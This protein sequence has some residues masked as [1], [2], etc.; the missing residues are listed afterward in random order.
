LRLTASRGIII[1]SKNNP[2]ALTRRYD[3]TSEVNRMS[4]PSLRP[5]VPGR[6]RGFTL[7]ELLVVIGI[8]ALLIS[9]LLPALSKAR[10]SAITVK[11]A[12]ALRQIGMGYQLY[13]NDQRG[14][15][16][17]AKLSPDTGSYELNGFQH[18]A[19]APAYWYNFVAYYVNQAAVGG[20]IQT[21]VDADAA[22]KGVL[23]GCPAWE[24]YIIH[25]S[26]YQIGYGMN[27]WPTMSLDNPSLGGVYP[28]PAERAE[29]GNGA[30]GRFFRQTEWTH[31]AERCL[32][33]DSR[34]WAAE[35]DKVPAALS[36]PPAVVPQSDINNSATYNGQGQTLIDIYRHG[37]YP[38]DS[39]AGT[40]DPNGG[41]IAFNILYCDGHVTTQKDAKQAYLSLRQRFPN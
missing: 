4:R 30:T 24:K 15:W 12:S 10:K 35:A 5:A 32:C 27:V 9:I 33:A 17:L 39:A 38:G 1:Y 34:F 18:T 22:H 2:A 28:M 19:S 7:V 6:A 25:P 11:C 13:S 14:W 37:T 41:S 20:A 23:W 36:Y 26:E 21:G 16:P 29:L 8:I 31:A 3:P 40:L